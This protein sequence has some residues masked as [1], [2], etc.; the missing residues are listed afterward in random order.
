MKEKKFETVIKGK[1]ARLKMINQSMNKSLMEFQA[2]LGSEEKFNMKVCSDLETIEASI[3]RYVNNEKEF[4]DTVKD[5]MYMEFDYNNL[6]DS[7]SCRSSRFEQIEKEMKVIHRQ[8]PKFMSNWMRAS[9]GFKVAH[10]SV[11]EMKKIVE[12]PKEFFE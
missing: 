6:E 12:R 4:M 8:Y 10:S 7:D 1:Q 9:F 2:K 11:T 3:E 5:L